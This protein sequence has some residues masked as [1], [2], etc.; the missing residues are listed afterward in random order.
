MLHEGHRTAFT[1]AEKDKV[2]VD[3]AKIV[4]SYAKDSRTGKN[5]YV[6]LRIPCE[7]GLRE[8]GRLCAHEKT[9]VPIENIPAFPNCSSPFYGNMLNYLNAWDS[10]DPRLQ[11][12]VRTYEQG[13]SFRPCL[14]PLLDRWMNVSEKAVSETYFQIV[15]D[16]DFKNLWEELGYFCSDTQTRADMIYLDRTAFLD[17]Y[18]TE[19]EEIRKTR[20]AE[21]NYLYVTRRLKEI[22]KEPKEIKEL[23]ADEC[24]FLPDP[25]FHYVAQHTGKLLE[26]LKELRGKVLDVYSRT[27]VDREH[28]LELEADLNQAVDTVE[29]VYRSACEFQPESR[30]WVTMDSFLVCRGG[31]VLSFLSSGQEYYEYCVHWINE[32]ED[33]IHAMIADCQE[34]LAR[35]QRKYVELTRD[36]LEVEGYSYQKT[37]EYLENYEEVIFEGDTEKELLAPVYIE[38]VSHAYK[39]ELHR[40]VTNLIG[41]LVSFLGAPELSVFLGMINLMKAVKDGDL[42]A[43]YMEAFGLDEN[44]ERRLEPVLGEAGYKAN[45]NLSMALT[46]ISFFMKSKEEWIEE[47]KITVFCNNTEHIGW[48]EFAGDY[49]MVHTAY[50]RYDEMGKLVM[51][52]MCNV[53]KRREYVADGG[54]WNITPAAKVVM[55]NHVLDSEEQ[56]LETIYKIKD[57]FDPKH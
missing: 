41:I 20:Q 54:D 13:E 49:D 3:G 8:E 4:C 14:Q 27:L 24:F 44:L 7:H 25:D 46:V 42:L 38:L 18:T 10:P 56:E 30:H 15:L 9:C 2:V 34:R 26:A 32:I 23:L 17:V 50:A 11:Y 29:K 52:C 53:E 36:N 12:A 47:I 57:A 40:N 21:E 6:Y 55:W 39:D 28:F 19:E 48:K 45:A 31:G 35:N 37:M 33:L 43:G 1:Q 51:P 16:F 22:K 5:P